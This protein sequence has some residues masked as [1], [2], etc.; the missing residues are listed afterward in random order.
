[1]TAD[2]EWTDASILRVIDLGNEHEWMPVY[3]RV[4]RE[5]FPGSRLFIEPGRVKYWTDAFADR[6]AQRSYVGSRARLLLS[7][8][9]KSPPLLHGLLR[10]S[11][12]AETDKLRLIQLIITASK[13]AE[14]EALFF[15]AT[16]QMLMLTLLQEEQ[17]RPGWELCGIR[18]APR[19]LRSLANIVP[20]SHSRR[21][22][23]KSRRRPN[24]PPKSAH[25]H[26]GMLRI[27]LSASALK[28]PVRRNVARRPRLQSWQVVLFLK[29]A[30]TDTQEVAFSW[31]A[32]FPEL[33]CRL[34]GYDLADQWQRRIRNE[35]ER[36]AQ[37]RRGEV[38]AALRRYQPQLRGIVRDWAGQAIQRWMADMKRR[39]VPSGGNESVG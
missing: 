18:D 19:L 22:A 5:G 21:L 15:E 37:V 1:M 39:F 11:E 2:T 20:P 33:L 7:C 24:R 3:G 6:L 30:D 16:R 27:P 35:L 29:F 38:V 10:H 32:D 14:Q 8:A 36:L 26:R 4:V 31:V 13:E 34:A 12:I 23:G 17:G 9:L 25:G 28:L